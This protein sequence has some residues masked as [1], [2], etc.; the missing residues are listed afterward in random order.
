MSPERR[1]SWPMSRRPVPPSSCDAVARPSAKASV[2]FRSTL[3]MPR[4]P[5]VPN[6][7]VMPHAV[8]DPA[9]V[10]RHGRDVPMALAGSAA[11]RSI[12]APPTRPD[13]GTR[14]QAQATLAGR[15]R[16]LGRGGSTGPRR[17]RPARPRARPTTSSSPSIGSTT[18]STSCVPGARRPTATDASMVDGSSESRAG[19]GPGEGDLDRGRRERVLA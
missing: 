3:A 16:G 18:T 1:V 6:R 17:P 19:S 11:P 5:S 2:G 10:E 12:R 9:V 7:R 8:A 13:G 4:M 14:K 15:T